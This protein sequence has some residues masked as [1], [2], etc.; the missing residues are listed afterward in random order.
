MEWTIKKERGR[1]KQRQEGLVESLAQRSKKER[2]NAWTRV[3]AAEVLRSG[4][5]WDIYTSKDLIVIS[6]VAQRD[7]EKNQF[8][9]E[10]N[11]QR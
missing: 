9:E 2:G 1:Q 7:G 4:Q 11:P 6:F 10:K 5:S 3:L 8:S